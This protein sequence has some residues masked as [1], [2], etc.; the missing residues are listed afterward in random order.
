[1]EH[2]GLV[3]FIVM[4]PRCDKKTLDVQPGIFLEDAGSWKFDESKPSPLAS[5][6]A[7]L[8]LDRELK[9]FVWVSSNLSNLW[10]LT[11]RFDSGLE[12]A[13]SKN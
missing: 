4:S 1:M 11:N 12:Q 7:A 10:P 5:G 3:D 6:G 2:P 9:I 8:T 13:L